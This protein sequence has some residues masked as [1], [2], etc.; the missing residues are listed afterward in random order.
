[1]GEGWNGGGWGT[2][3]MICMQRG[4]VWSEMIYLKCLFSVSKIG[5]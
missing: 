4:I 3:I 1:M 5:L 2:F